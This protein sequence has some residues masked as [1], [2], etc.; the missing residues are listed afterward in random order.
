[1]R[2]KKY[3]IE[4]KKLEKTMIGFN[5][6]DTSIKNISHLISNILLE[7]NISYETITKPHISIAQITGKYEKDELVRIINKIPKVSFNPKSLTKFY[8]PNIKKDFIVIEYRQNDKY[9]EIFKDIAHKFDV[10]LFVGGMKPHVSLFMVEEG[11][12]T[13]SIFDEIKK[14]AKKLPKIKPRSVVLFNKKAQ[15]E[16]VRN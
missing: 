6:D 12:L 8:G 10:R 7:N 14:V 9:L 4:T 11:K 3:I 1:M 5:V 13:D 16:F 2:L 15:P